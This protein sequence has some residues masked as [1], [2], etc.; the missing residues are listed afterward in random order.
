MTS[1][2]PGELDKLYELQ[3]SRQAIPPVAKHVNRGQTLAMLRWMLTAWGI[4]LDADPARCWVWSDLHVNHAPIIT[5]GHRPFAT[6]RQMQEHLIDAW[7]GCVRRNDVIV[8]VGDLAIG[9]SSEAVDAMVRNLPGRKLVVAGNHEFWAAGGPPKNYAVCEVMPTL[10]VDGKHPAVM[11][12]EPLDHVPRGW[13]NLH[14][15][16]HGPVR[17]VS[18]RHV[19]VNVEQIGYQPARLDEVLGQATQSPKAGSLRG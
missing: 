8:C 12:H 9:G 15:H 18:T 3:L 14:G 5:H 10:L 11:T 17:P 7:R 16:L 13:I 19:N 2:S 4:R 6:L 1:P